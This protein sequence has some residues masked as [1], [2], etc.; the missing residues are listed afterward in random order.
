MTALSARGNISDQA[1][2][3]PGMSLQILSDEDLNRIHEA[4]L[5]VLEE[6]GIDFKNCQGAISILQNHGC[7]VRDGPFS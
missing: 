4:S 2:R 6:Y 1:K 5:T 7:V 3:D